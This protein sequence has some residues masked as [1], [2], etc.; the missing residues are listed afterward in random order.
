MRQI[1]INKLGNKVT[2][3]IPLESDVN[4][5][6]LLQPLSEGVDT[7]TANGFVEDFITGETSSK[8]TFIERSFANSI[9]I[10]NKVITIRGTDIRA[11]VLKDDPTEKRYVMYVGD[12]A[13]AGGYAYQPTNNNDLSIEYTDINEVTTYKYKPRAELDHP[14]PSAFILKYW[15]IIDEPK[16]DSNLF[17]NRGVNNVFASIKRLKN[18]KKIKE[19]EKT[20]FFFFKIYKEEII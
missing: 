19:L 14:S 8:F 9:V 12:V 18:F 3:I 16:L 2:F 1:N 6:G 11:V 5:M 7:D 20:G 4:V 17:I 13:V 10:I 15:G